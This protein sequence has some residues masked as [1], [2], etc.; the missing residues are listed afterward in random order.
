[1]G[2]FGIMS[3]PSTQKIIR[4]EWQVL[5]YSMLGL[6]IGLTIE[7]HLLSIRAIALSIFPTITEHYWFFSAYVIVFALSGYLNELLRKL[8]KDHFVRM[9]LLCFLF[10]CVI[11]FFS[12]REYHGFFW[13]QL[14]WFFVMYVTG[15]FFRL[16]NPIIS[17]KTCWIFLI[18]S[19]FLL[20]ASFAVFE[21]L[22][23]KMAFLNGYVTYFRWSNSPVAIVASVSML[24]LAIRSKG[25]TNQLVNKVASLVFGIYLLHENFFIKDLLWGRFFNA[26]CCS[27]VV[28]RVA[29]F[30]FSVIIVFAIG[31]IVELTRAKLE[32]KFM[33]KPCKYISAKI[34]LC[35]NKITNLISRGC[36]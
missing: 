16:F 19:I 3:G 36:A 25:Y 20:M 4:I 13:N 30:L 12:L 5:F 29:H 17:V 22:A 18:S 28:D 9:L 23:P 15:A 14:I 7:R 26:S 33:A 8:P 27:T 32:R 1:M 2:Y 10:W 24:S 35:F 34:N 21:L 11:P 6:V 31:C